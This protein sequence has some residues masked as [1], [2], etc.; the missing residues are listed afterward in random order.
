MQREKTVTSFAPPLTRRSKKGLVLL[1]FL[2]A[3]DFVGTLSA[4]HNKDDAGEGKNKTDAQDDVIQV[5][6]LKHAREKR[7]SQNSDCNNQEEN[8]SI[9]FQSSHNLY[10]LCY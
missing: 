3:S 9:Q 4:K 7:H 8:T 2:L 1:C 6:I 10:Q 5:G